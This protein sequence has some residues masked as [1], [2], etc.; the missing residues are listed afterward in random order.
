MIS[1]K[2]YHNLNKDKLSLNEM[3]R[4][5]NMVLLQNQQEFILRQQSHRR[6]G[7]PFETSITDS[8]FL[9]QENGDYLLQENDDR[10]IL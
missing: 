5:Y 6:S 3:V 8:E 10:I 1:W 4:Q 7:S 2:E 9:L